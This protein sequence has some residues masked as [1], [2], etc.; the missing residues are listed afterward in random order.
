MPILI[1]EHCDGTFAS[2]YAPAMAN[3]REEH[4]RADDGHDFTGYLTLP[5]AGSGA[6]PGRCKSSLAEGG[7]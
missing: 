4:I 3:A 2:M 7:R 6:G 1:R 5:A